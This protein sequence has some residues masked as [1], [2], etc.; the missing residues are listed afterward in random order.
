MDAKVDRPHERTGF[1]HPDLREWAHEHRDQLVWACLTL[2][3]HWLAQGSP[4]P[5]VTPLG[6]FESWTRVIGG[7]VACAGVGGF[8]SN[9]KAFY[10][11]ADTE[12]ATWRAFIGLWWETFGVAPVGV[13]ELWPLVG[14]FDLGLGD[15]TERSQRSRLGKK[16]AGVRGRRFDTLRVEPAAEEHNAARFALKKED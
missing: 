7:V 13:K 5:A 1:R 3:T 10:A 16:L 2:T 15:G 12:S 9:T 14:D 4:K 8:L 6:G 11:E